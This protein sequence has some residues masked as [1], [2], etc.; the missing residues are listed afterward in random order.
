MYAATIEQYQGAISN[1]L[2]EGQIE[3]LKTIYYFPGSSATAKEL[4]SALNYSGYQAANRQVGQIGRAISQY[5]GIIPPDYSGGD[6]AMRPAYYL[7]IG[8]YDKKSGWMMW[9]ELKKALENLKLVSREESLERNLSFKDDLTS[10]ISRNAYLFAWNPN[11]WDWVNLDRDF[12]EYCICGKVTLSWICRS[13]KNI[14]PGDRAFLMRLGSNPK[15]IMGSGTVVSEPFWSDEDKD[16]P[17]VLIEFDVLLHPERDEILT[18]DL[19]DAANLKGQLWTP[20][21]SGISIKRD[22]VYELEKTWFE[23]LGPSIFERDFMTDTTESTRTFIEGAATQILQ[24]RYERNAYA[25]DQCLR[26]YGYACKVCDFDFEKVY[27]NIGYKFI[28]VHHLTKMSAIGEEYHINPVEDLRPVCP[29]C[30]A[31]LHKR[32][33]PLKIEELK[34]IIM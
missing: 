19:L 16:V 8:D 15:G 18:L 17:C 3:T 34:K 4:A 32:N 1:A 24:T 6:R 21:A 20:Q 14:N 30:H 12:D 27:G 5:T 7:L 28:H 11:K 9:A 2:S 23:F 10:I 25:R 22:L 29:N 31:M 26:H 33:P 13:Y